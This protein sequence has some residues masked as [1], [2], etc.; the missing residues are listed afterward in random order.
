MPTNPG[1]A[2]A[3]VMGA[4]LA[5]TA[6]ATV[7]PFLGNP[8]GRVIADHVHA[9]YP[10]Y[11]PARLAVAVTMYLTGLVIVG[12]LGLVTWAACIL[13]ARSRL[14]VARW[15]A[16]AAFVVGTS[17]ALFD[18]SVRDTSG[19]TG[20]PLPVG[21]LGVLPSVP[22]AVAVVLLWRGRNR[23]SSTGTRSVRPASRSRTPSDRQWM[24]AAAAPVLPR[25]SGPR[26]PT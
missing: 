13:L 11:G 23:L 12:G 25:P 18:L 20:L 9:G 14:P 4:G 10:S 15:V 24:R 2:A 26:P 7:I 3:G 6:L 16:A 8:V 1:R 22:G 19:D 21:L 5:L 17:T